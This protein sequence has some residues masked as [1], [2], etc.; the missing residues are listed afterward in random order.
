M[1]FPILYFLISLDIMKS[2]TFLKMNFINFN[3]SGKAIIK[4]IFKTRGNCFHCIN[5]FSALL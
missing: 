3:I 1:N 5:K 2:M 4:F